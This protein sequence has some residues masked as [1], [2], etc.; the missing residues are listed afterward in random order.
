MVNAWPS[1]HQR[2]GPIGLLLAMPL[3]AVAMVLVKML[4]I[5]DT[6]GDEVEPMREKES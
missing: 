6:L 5:Q 4:Y 2:T 1:S 3:I